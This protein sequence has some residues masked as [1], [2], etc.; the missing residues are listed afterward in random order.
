VGFTGSVGGGRALFDLACARPD[1]IPFYGELGSLNPVV[2]TA[3]AVAE[4]AEDIAA[5]LLTSYTNGVGQFCTK[6]GVVFVPANADGQRLATALAE[7]TRGYEPGAMLAAR[8]RDGFL[9]GSTA[10]AGLSGVTELAAS[11]AP[12]GAGF[13]APARLVSVSARTLLDGPDLDTVFDECFGPLTVLVTY[14]DEAELLAALDR[15][16]GSL[17]ATVHAAAGEAPTA[18]LNL[19]RPRAGRLVWNGYPTGVAVAWAT[20]HGGPYPSSTDSRSTSVGAAAIGRWLRPIAYQSTPDPLLPPA[21]QEANPWALP[22]RIDGV[23][24]LP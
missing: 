22:R 2:L 14:A 4:R 5:G 6:P 19:L 1:P 17:T 21:L 3:G 18:V 7:G 9:A 13:F 20:Q 23:L 16:P 12:D 15:L 8:I 11:T 10:R 24:Q